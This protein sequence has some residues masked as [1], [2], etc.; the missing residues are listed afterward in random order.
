M[1]RQ[2]KAASLGLS[3]A[4]AKAAVKRLEATETIFWMLPSNQSA[5]SSVSKSVRRK[6]YS[7]LCP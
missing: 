1:T 2:S 6:E 7:S 3:Y 4:L 5:A